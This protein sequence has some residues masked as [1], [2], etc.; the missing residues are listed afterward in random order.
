MKKEYISPQGIFEPLGWSHAI[1]ADGTIYLS[2]M[3][4]FDE[5]RNI[6]TGGF[7]AQTVKA[8]ENIKLTLEA[9]GASM[10]DVVKMT[11]YVTDMGNIIKFREIRARYFSPP[12]PSSTGVEVS[13]LILP[14]LLVEIEAVAVVD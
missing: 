11:V 4:G 5:Q 12:M 1:K 6:V 9:A 13:R 3:V 7:E 14:E 8:F 10:K 2:G